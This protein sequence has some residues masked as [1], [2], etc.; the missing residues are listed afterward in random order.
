MNLIKYIKAILKNPALIKENLFQFKK[1]VKLIKRVSFMRNSMLKMAILKLIIRQYYLQKCLNYGNKQNNGKNKKNDSF[2]SNDIHIEVTPLSGESQKLNKVV[3]SPN[4][5][6]PK[7]QEFME[8]QVPITPENKEK[9]LYE[10]EMT[11]TKQSNDLL[12]T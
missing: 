8:N 12:Y 3:P 11:E 5:I 6:K 1:G 4:V 9:N 7:F 10:N 2:K